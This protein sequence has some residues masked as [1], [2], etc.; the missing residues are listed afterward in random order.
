LSIALHRPSGHAFMDPAATPS[1]KRK[2]IR[3]PNSELR[4]REYLTPKEVEKLIKAAKDGRWGRRDANARPRTRAH[5]STWLNS[6]SHTSEARRPCL[7][8]ISTKVA[9]LGK[10]LAPFICAD[11]PVRFRSVTARESIRSS[12]AQSGTEWPRIAN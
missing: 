3:P 1:W 10:K 6:K 2:N 5:N 7:N 8:A 11:D 9:R 12:A 4:Q